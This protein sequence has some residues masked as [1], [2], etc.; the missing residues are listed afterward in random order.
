MGGLLPLYGLW[1]RR[2]HG[3]GRVSSR[4]KGCRGAG[5]DGSGSI[6]GYAPMAV[7]A[8]AR[9]MDKLR[10]LSILCRLYK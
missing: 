1:L 10:R 7:P 6:D 9:S 5:E 4:G 3:A 8:V 2:I